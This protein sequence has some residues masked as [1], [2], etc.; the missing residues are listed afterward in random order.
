MDLE[1]N[2]NVNKMTQT[3][4]PIGYILLALLLTACAHQDGYTQC[5]NPRPEICTREY[6]PVCAERKSGESIA[7]ETYSNA[8]TACADAVVI[9]HRPDAC[10]KD[11]NQ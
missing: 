2:R 11:K 10:T 1:N 9:R 3:W 7:Q 6:A 4:Q 5:K 8:C